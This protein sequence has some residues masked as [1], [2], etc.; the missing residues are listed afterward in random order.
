[1]K[2]I[3][4]I[5]L[6]APLLLSAL[7]GADSLET[8]TPESVPEN[9]YSDT[10]D[11]MTIM[12]SSDVSKTSSTPED[13]TIPDIPE[14]AADS[15]LDS[16]AAEA[17]RDSLLAIRAYDREILL[18]YPLENDSL[19]GGDTLYPF[20]LY[21]SDA[22][23]VGELLRFNP[24]YLYVP[25]TLTSQL[26]RFLP[27]GFSGPH[28]AL[29]PRDGTIPELPR[30]GRGTDALSMV[31]AR[32]FYLQP[33]GRLVYSPQPVDLI[34]PETMILFE[35]GQGSVFG[36]KLLNLRFARPITEN[37]DIGAFTNHRTLDRRNFSHSRGN[38]YG[39]YR[40]IYQSLGVDTSLVSSSG[41]NPLTNEHISSLRAVWRPAGSA[42]YRFSYQYADL[43]NDIAA[44]FPQ[45]EMGNEGNQSTLGWLALSQFEHRLAAGVSDLR[46]AGLHI[47]ADIQMESEN[48]TLEP[49]TA[50]ETFQKLGGDRNE[51]KVGLHPALPTQIGVF[52]LRMNT[53][54]QRVKRFDRSQ[55]DLGRYRLEGGYEGSARSGLFTGTAS[56]KAGYVGVSLEDSLENALTWRTELAVGSPPVQARLFAFQ[57]VMP[58]IV[59]PDTIFTLVPGQ[60]ADRYRAFGAQTRLKYG[61]VGLLLGATRLQGVE[62]ESVELYWPGGIPPYREPQW[63]FSV[64]PVLG[65]LNRMS[66]TSGWLFSNTKPY[67][68]STSVFSYYSDTTKTHPRFFLDLAVTYWSERDTFSFGGIDTWGRPVLDVYIKTAVQI[69]TFRLFFKTDNF[70]NRKL[71]YVPGY[72]M[73]GL[74]FRWGFNWLLQG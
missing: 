32:E 48:S 45:A 51:L 20:Q 7:Y 10:S 47:D 1:M 16:L 36:E 42:Q 30:Y 64:A 28:S 19:Y 71:A 74:T 31:D 58:S 39:T 29:L 57:D 12:P 62:P 59:P 9:V 11:T 54:N 73:P 70:F 49:I 53:R 65:R 2:N 50:P 67:V 26:N 55:W 68:K 60:F 46:T 44:E 27:Y 41:V 40:D 5:T 6:F 18:H 38:I 21:G 4:K 69:K 15:T 17:I 22:S 24:L 14:V 56:A 33:L 8:V 37:A 63:V 72:Y 25:V 61:R 52:S 35:G 34:A 13:T 66:L 3:V 23:G 43:S